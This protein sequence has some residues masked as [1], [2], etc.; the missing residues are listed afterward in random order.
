[1]EEYQKL[2][3]DG[4]PDKISNNGKGEVPIFRRL[5]S[6]EFLPHLAD[7]LEEEAWEI[8]DSKDDET[9]K[10]ELVDF[11]E[12]LDTILIIK[13]Y[14]FNAVAQIINGIKAEKPSYETPRDLAMSMLKQDAVDSAASLKTAI[15]Y[16]SNVFICLARAYNAQKEISDM[17]G[18]SPNFLAQAMIAKRQK[19]GGFALGIFLEDVVEK[20]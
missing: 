6:D 12:L 8:F 13:N 9:L 18:L 16:E 15:T 4:I 11:K 20:S 19:V 1:M 3:R 7:K 14:N 2:V 17:I 10:A 5:E